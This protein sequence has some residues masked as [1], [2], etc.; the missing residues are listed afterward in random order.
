M[1]KNNTYFQARPN[2]IYELGWFVGKLDREN[3][4]IL[5]QDGAKIHSDIDGISPIQFN[6]NIDE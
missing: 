2:V 4:R 6:E 5:L 3:V 1:G